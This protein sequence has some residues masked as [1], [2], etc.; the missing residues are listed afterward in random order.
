M[1]SVIN[2]NQNWLF[3]PR[4]LALAAPDD[5]FV[6][7]TIPHSNA[8]LPHHNFDVSD[9]AFVSTYRKRFSLPEPMGR[10]RVFL[11]FDGV[12]TACEVTLN[13]HR[14][15][16]HDGGYVPFSFDITEHLRAGENVLHVQVDSTERE[17]IPPF[18]YVIDYLTFGGIYRD[19]KLRYVEP[20]YI[21]NAFVRTQAVMS[22]DPKAELDLW[23]RN[24]LPD[25]VE[26][27]INWICDY[28]VREDSLT[29]ATL[30][31]PVEVRVHVPPMETIRYTCTLDVSTAKRWSLDDPQL[32]H[33]EILLSAFLGADTAEDRMEI[34]FGLREAVFRPDGFYLNDEKIK[35][36]GLNRH[37]MYPYIG[38]AAPERLQRKDADILKD[39]LGCNIVRTS[40]Y[41]QSPHFLD[42]CDEIG[43]LV[44]EEIPGWQFIGDSDWKALALRDLQV[45]IERDRNHPSIILW[46]VR[47][48][49]SWDDDTLY[50][51]TNELAREL[52]PTRQTG[53]VRYFQASTFLEDV[54]T[55]NDFSDTIIA[56]QHTPHLVTEFSGHM[57]PTKSFDNE[58]R[59]VEHA[60]RHARIQNAAAERAD[61]TG[62]IGWCAFD[63]NTHI[64][65]GAGDRVCYHGV[66]DMFR[67]PKFAAYVYESQIDP[68]QRIVLRPGTFYAFGDRDNYGAK[69]A[70]DFY[71]FSNCDEIEVVVGDELMGRFQPDREHFG[72]LPHPPFKVGD[73]Q[74]WYTQRL[75]VPDAKITGYYRGQ[76][77][78]EANLTT[79]KLPRALILTA[80]D[81]ELRADGSDMMRVSFQLVDKFGMRLPHAHAVVTLEIDGP[82]DLIGVNPFPLVGGQAALFLKA[83]HTAGEVKVR[84]TA[85]PYGFTAETKV[86]IV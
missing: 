33:C 60:L 30:D 54:F 55:F 40:H 72:H 78:A 25:A 43:L 74:L 45:M 82:A 67:L 36:R 80:D 62:A 61:V 73:G 48:N 11:D 75:R 41:P 53:G 44:F 49:E 31:D 24:H 51:A 63:Y 56:P 47:V 35:L 17:D 10:R 9:Y 50:K 7:V 22:A 29:R 20:V 38:I 14:L 12:M 27:A 8:L 2:F 65:F 3:A 79:D 39:E 59:Q 18:G 69:C 83:R 86:N 4:V 76:V 85:Q 57:Y 21:R 58:E 6:P 19:V 5:E 15:G 13:G 64:E 68:E 70:F 37:Q 26:V 32:V 66:M 81:D 52:D 16:E 28:E 46:G 1:R 84:A 34:R 42:R 71:V 77:V 23:I